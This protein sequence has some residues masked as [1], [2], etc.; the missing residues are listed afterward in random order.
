MNATS[1]EAAFIL[2]CGV[3]QSLAFR[4]LVASCTEKQEKREGEKP[5]RVKINGGRKKD[6]A[7]GGAE[8]EGGWRTSVSGIGREREWRKE[9]E[10]KRRRANRRAALPLS[11]KSCHLTESHFS[12]EQLLF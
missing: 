10:L 2:G 8:Q 4:H 7:T 6:K 9:S 3:E 1:I 12:P 5:S 11:E